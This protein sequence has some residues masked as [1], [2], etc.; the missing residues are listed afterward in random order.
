MRSIYTEMEGL[1]CGCDGLP[2][3][4]GVTYTHF[5]P[6]LEGG[7]LKLPYDIIWRAGFKAGDTLLLKEACHAESGGFI[8]FI[9]KQ[10]E[11]NRISLPS[12][13]AVAK[14]K[15]KLDEDYKIHIRDR[16]VEKLDVKE[17]DTIQIE[18]F[19]GAIYLSK[20]EKPMPI[21]LI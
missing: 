6:L 11:Y 20:Y 9:E 8:I 13:R 5:A 19:S 15:T 7:L 14:Y 1:K 18:S 3:Y 10:K 12:I 17:G 21:E 2:D 4:D 16:W